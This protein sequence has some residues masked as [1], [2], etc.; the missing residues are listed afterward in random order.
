MT[1]KKPLRTKFLSNLFSEWILRNFPKHKKETITSSVD[2]RTTI[3]HWL[4]MEERLT[5]DALSTK[6][7]KCCFRCCFSLKKSVEKS[8]FL[9]KGVGKH[10]VVCIGSGGTVFEWRRKF[11]DNSL[12][13]YN[14][15]TI[16][17]QFTYNSLSLT[18]PVL[19][20]WLTAYM[21]V[22]WRIK[23]ILNTRIEYFISWL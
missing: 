5:T 12:F 22:V 13:I 9:Q 15:F 18:I 6:M 14:S 4:L 17:L 10:C 19:Q 16:H 23:Y 1:E 20:F 2:E 21:N 7:A 8:R 11:I 3:L